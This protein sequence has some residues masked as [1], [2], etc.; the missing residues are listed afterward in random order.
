MQGYLHFSGIP[1]TL[2]LHEGR[3][4]N[5]K[6]HSYK[7]SS[8]KQGKKSSVKCKTKALSC[9][10]SNIKCSKF[11]YDKDNITVKSTKDLKFWK[12]VN[13]KSN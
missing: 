11:W 6:C 8:H 9:R 2:I 1:L 12:N 4:Q 10:A 13:C 7:P 3:L 5:A